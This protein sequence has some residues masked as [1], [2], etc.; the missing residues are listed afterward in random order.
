[1]K[2]LATDPVALDTLTVTHAPAA[3][4]A[5]HVEAGIE[6]RWDHHHSDHHI[7]VTKGTCRVLS[8]QLHAGASVYVPA[9]MDHSLKAGAW[10]CTF[11]SL[12]SAEQAI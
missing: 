12:E 5:I 8:R 1:V 10:G 2:T 4:E 11:F 7:I 3:A 6:L 9:G